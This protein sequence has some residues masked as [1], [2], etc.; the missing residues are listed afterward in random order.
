MKITIPELNM[1][2]TISFDHFIFNILNDAVKELESYRQRKDR[3]SN[4][5]RALVQRVSALTDCAL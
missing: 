3:D 2:I 5:Y 4:H 1:T